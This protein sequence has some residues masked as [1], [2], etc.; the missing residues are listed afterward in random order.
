M[1]SSA[2]VSADDRI[3]ALIIGYGNTLRSDDGV[4]PWLTE[5]LEIAHSA[6]LAQTARGVIA[7]ISATQLLPEHADPMS[8]ARLV[9]FVDAAVDVPPGETHWREVEPAADNGGRVHSFSPESLLRM[10]GQFGRV[11]EQ[12]LLLAIGGEAWGLGETFS[13]RVRQ[14][15][16]RLLGEIPQ[17]IA[18]ELA[19]L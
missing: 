5:A 12:A 18:T 16:D 1:S 9:V 14:T 4:G 7:F 2:E 13:E 19:K 10:A 17:R 15:A 6:G 8:R 3:D 11:P